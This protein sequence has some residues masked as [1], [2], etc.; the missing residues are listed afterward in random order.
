[1]LGLK[2]DSPGNTTVFLF[3]FPTTELHGLSLGD[4]FHILNVLSLGV[5]MRLKW[6]WRCHLL[7]WNVVLEEDNVQ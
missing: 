7:W 2:I 6:D 1:M 4:D 5:L 3:N